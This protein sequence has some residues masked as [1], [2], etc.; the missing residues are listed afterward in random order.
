MSAWANV[1]RPLKDRF[2]AKRYHFNKG[3]ASFTED[4]GQVVA[5]FEDGSEARGDLLIG[6]DGLRSAV[7]KQIFP[8]LEPAYCGYVAWRSIVDEDAIPAASRAWLKGGYWFALPPGEMFLAY[9]VPSKDPLR[10]GLRD[11]N[12]VW[13]RPVNDAAFRDLCT[14]SSGRHHLHGIPPPLIRPDVSAAIKAE[15]RRL[16]APHL[17]QIVE[18]SRPF[19]QPIF[20]VESPRL[21]TG[22]VMLLGDAAFVAR[23]HIGAGVT[24]AALDAL[25]LFNS[26]KKER[27][28]EAALARYD[29]LRSE[30]GR[31]CVARGRRLGAYIEARSRPERRW[32]PAQLDQRP[33]HVLQEVALSL[34]KIPE[35]HIEV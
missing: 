4:K 21:V 13:Y 20:D 3:F 10:P 15:A 33:E 29:R 34:D 6:A 18:S 2:P 25:S 5:R 17:A 28:L 35:L 8:D 32:T 30:Y 26:L 24:K 11:W 19:F 7:R 23:P 12:H 14:D 27:S 31:Q 9:E 22:R 1:Y 16:L